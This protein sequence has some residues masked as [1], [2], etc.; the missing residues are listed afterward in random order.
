[1]PEPPPSPLP[2]RHALFPIL[3]LS[4]LIGYGIV[5]RPLIGN[6]PAF[7]L[8]IIF[9]SAAAIAVTHQVALGYRWDAIMASIVGRLSRALPAL[10]IL[11]A[12]GILIA[13]WTI[14]GTIPMLVYYGIQLIH[15]SLIYLLAFLVPVVFSSLTGTSWGS[16][17]TIGVVIIGI[18]QAFGARLD[19]TAAAI[20]GGAF[21]GDKMSPLSDTTNLAALAAD[22]DLFD[23]IRSMTWTTLPSALVATLTYSALGLLFPPEGGSLH[24]ER[25]TAFLE[26]LAA[27]FVFHPLLLLPPLVVLVGSL[28]RYPTI[29]VLMT[30]VAV[31][32]LLT[33]SLQPF[34][35]TDLVQSL[36]RG[37]HVE[38]AA[39]STAVPAEVAALVNRGGLYALS[40]AIVIALMVFVFIGT[41]D[42]IRAMPVVV[43]RI[44]GGVRSRAGTILATL[45][46]TALTNATTSNQY[47]TS[48]I[49]G[50]AFKS[51]FDALSIPRRVLSRSLE[52]TG[53]MLESLVPWHATAVFMVA[54][55]GVPVAEY[56]PWQ[57]LSLTNFA[58]A[59]L[60]A[61]T[62]IG[63]G[64]ADGARGWGRANRGTGEPGSRGAGETG[65][66]GAGE[67]E[68]P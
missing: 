67:A 1:M 41:I 43:E 57:V 7:P 12:I 25:T 56:W 13:A 10:F 38:M 68:S 39:S 14:S 23:H 22:T 4:G 32:A 35:L 16:A 63:C 52:D 51:R 37:F 58:V 40:E 36:Y 28:R 15:P 26:G 11:F 42:H 6:Q 60:L 62:G 54:T 45:A 9:I 65:S 2:F 55:L 8:E 59:A 50:D 34:T 29:P 19:I 3:V 61:V 20:I 46:A 30:S 24:V 48:F 47:A 49:V 53:T 33:L 31:A 17:G 66:R 18:A 21:F 27:M 5:L 64:P 44:V